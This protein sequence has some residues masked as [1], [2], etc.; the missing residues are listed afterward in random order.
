MS[1]EVYGSGINFSYGVF[2][3]LLLFLLA[4]LLNLICTIFMAFHNHKIEIYYGRISGIFSLIQDKKE[5][6][7][8]INGEK[9]VVNGLFSID[10]CKLEC[11]ETYSLFSVDSLN[12]LGQVEH[13]V[14]EKST[15]MDAEFVLAEGKK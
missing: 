11:S 10:V 13:N 6:G 12:V 14:G 7:V 2:V 15:T 3:I 4:K 1:T 8:D 5:R 9:I